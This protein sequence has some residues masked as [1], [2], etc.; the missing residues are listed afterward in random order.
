MSSVLS[1]YSWLVRAQMALFRIQ[2]WLYQPVQ[3][4]EQDRSQAIALVLD[5]G[6]SSMEIWVVE[7]S[8]DILAHI[9]VHHQRLEP[10]GGY[11]L[12]SDGA[13]R[14]FLLDMCTYRFVEAAKSLLLQIDGVEQTK[15]FIDML[16]QKL[17]KGELACETK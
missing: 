9:V 12:C 16:F 14:T 2:T 5:E 17:Y 15:M 3:A 4:D 1:E 7:S 8:P 10:Y 13:G 6:V 11:L